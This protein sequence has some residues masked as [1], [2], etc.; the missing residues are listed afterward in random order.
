MKLIYNDKYQTVDENL[1]DSNVG[2]RKG[3][4]ISNHI[5]VVN[6][7]INQTI[8]AK[9][10]SVDI[11]IMDYRQCFDSMWLQECINDKMTNCA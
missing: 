1:S 2:A 3:K 8:D 11:Q 9:N 10:E 7:I 6:G 4:S 5:F